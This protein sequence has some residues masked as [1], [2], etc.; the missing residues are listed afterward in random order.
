M[1]THARR[2]KIIIKGNNIEYRLMKGLHVLE[3]FSMV[4]LTMK[5]GS[6]WG[7]YTRK[8]EGPILNGIRISRKKKERY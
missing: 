6:L 7:A 2:K 5:P 1:L 4:P 8:T 3:R